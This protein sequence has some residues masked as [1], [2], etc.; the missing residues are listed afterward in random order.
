MENLESVLMTYFYDMSEWLAG[1]KVRMKEN[2]SKSRLSI[3][4][5]IQEDLKEVES[6]SDEVLS[7]ELSDAIEELKK[8][9]DEDFVKLKTNLSEFEPLSE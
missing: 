9:T 4:E 8:M 1:K 7:E 3:I 5:L 6:F 2:F